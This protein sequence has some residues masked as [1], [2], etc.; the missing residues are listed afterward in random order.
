[1]YCQDCALNF[2]SSVPPHPWH[3]AAFLRSFFLSTAV[4]VVTSW[5]REL[6]IEWGTCELRAGRIRLLAPPFFQCP[7]CQRRSLFSRGLLPLIPI[8]RPSGTLGNV[9]FGCRAVG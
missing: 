6:L 2:T 3:R 7:S 5:G 1:M 4:M 8:G 9:V